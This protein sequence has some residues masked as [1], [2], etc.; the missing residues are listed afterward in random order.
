PLTRLISLLDGIE[1]ISR[2]SQL[3]IACPGH[4]GD[5]NV[6]PTVIFDSNDAGECKRAME[7]FDAVMKCGLEL[8]GTITGE[9]G[10]GLLKRNWLKT[11]LGKENW[12]LQ[13][14]I[15]NVA[16]PNGIMNP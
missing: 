8:G 1:D 9:H 3:P 12:E 6:H 4:A 11:E 5:G 14:T 16:D 7:A 10:V 13:R 2:D 15:Q